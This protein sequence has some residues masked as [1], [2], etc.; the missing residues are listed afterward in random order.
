MEILAFLIS[1]PFLT[2]VAV[3]AVIIVLT[4]YEHPGWAALV[5]LVAV[6]F[7]E[8]VLGYPVFE[9]IADN[10]G[11]F[12]AGIVGYVLI[13]VLWSHFKW[14]LYLRE[15]R[16]DFVEYQ[17]NVASG[18]KSKVL[19]DKSLKDNFRYETNLR[20]FPP[21]ALNHKSQIVTWT[22]YWP[23][24]AFWTVFDDF[25]LNLFNTVFEYFK[26]SY[27]RIRS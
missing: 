13:G 4:E 22:M 2:F 19:D 26:M 8:W 7:F 10:F 5:V 6:A 12:L 23:F 17:A 1:L 20:D 25:V 3:C 16:D 18:K 11:W 15:V 9:S 21:K 27:Q 14:L 24:S